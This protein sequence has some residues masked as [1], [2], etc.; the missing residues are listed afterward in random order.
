VAKAMPLLLLLAI[1]SFIVYPVL[2]VHSVDP[3]GLVQLQETWATVLLIAALGLLNHAIGG[4]WWV[5]ARIFGVFLTGPLLADQKYFADG[6][7][8][9]GKEL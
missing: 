3:Y 2:P 7:A 8:F 5:E 1:L 9:F 6:E 4:N